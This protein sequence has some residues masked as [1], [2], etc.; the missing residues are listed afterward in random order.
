MRRDR[1]LR[2]TGNQFHLRECLSGFAGKRTS[3]KTPRATHATTVTTTASTIPF[4]VQLQFSANPDGWQAS[5][6]KAPD[7]PKR[8]ARTPELYRSLKVANQYKTNLPGSAVWIFTSYQQRQIQISPRTI[9]LRA[10][11][12]FPLTAPASTRV[13]SGLLRSP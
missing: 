6:V 2:Q 8:A 1:Q 9:T 12:R 5:Q 10:D 13:Q 7:S 11:R 3:P 4:R